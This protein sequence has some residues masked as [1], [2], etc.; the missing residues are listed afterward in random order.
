MDVEEVI[1]DMFEANGDL[2]L[3]DISMETDKD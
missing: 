3:V 1:N 2:E